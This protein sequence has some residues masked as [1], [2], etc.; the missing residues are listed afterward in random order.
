MWV[1]VSSPQ[2]VSAAA[3]GEPSLPGSSVGS[4]QGRQFSTNFP[5][6]ST[7]HRLQ[8]STNSYEVGHA[9]MRY[10]PSSTDPSSLGPP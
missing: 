8:S 7:S 6:V 9:S 3:Q 4:P 5:N 10:S 1:K 2:T